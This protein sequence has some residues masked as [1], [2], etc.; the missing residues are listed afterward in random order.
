MSIFL[1]IMLLFVLVLVP[2]IKICEEGQRIAVVKLGKVG[3]LRGPGLCIVTPYVD[4]CGKVSIGDRG[5][6]VAAGVLKIDWKLV[7]IKSPESFSPGTRVTIVGFEEEGGHGIARVEL[8]K[9]QRKEFFCEKCG[10][11]MK[12]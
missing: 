1:P 6:V 2:Y 12:L 7:P 8:D 10:H 5:E 9:D 4:R 11:T 3:P